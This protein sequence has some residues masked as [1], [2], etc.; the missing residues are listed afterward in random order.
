MSIQI[1]QGK[2]LPSGAIDPKTDQWLPVPK[3][4][5]GNKLNSGDIEYYAVING[6]RVPLKLNTDYTFVGRNTEIN[7]DDIIIPKSYVA[8]GGY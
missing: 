3:I 8:V 7:L 2:L 5:H 1:K 6:K 4:E